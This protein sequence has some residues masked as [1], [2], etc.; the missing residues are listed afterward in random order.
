MWDAAPDLS[1][2][3]KVEVLLHPGF[4]CDCEHAIC[5]AAP[6]VKEAKLDIMCHFVCLCVMMW[7]KEAHFDGYI[8]LSWQSFPISG[9]C[10]CL[11][12]L[13]KGLSGRILAHY[14]FST[15]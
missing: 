2:H 3:V 11:S 8:E 1:F 10:H 9:F 14:P 15:G 12:L 7:S 4:T 6:G 5:P 13:Q